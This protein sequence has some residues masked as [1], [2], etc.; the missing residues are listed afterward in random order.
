MSQNQIAR[1]RYLYDKFFNKRYNKKVIQT[2]LVN[3]NACS[4]AASEI[5][6]VAERVLKEFKSDIIGAEFGVAY[7]GGVEAIGKMWKG[8]G[9]IYG[10]D[11][12]E[13]QPKHIAEGTRAASA[14]D[15]WC[16]KYGKEKLAF[17][18]IQSVLD[19]QGL[20]NVKLV[21]GLITSDTK[22]D[23]IPYLD[24]VLLDLDFPI[25]MRQAY[26]LVKDKMTNGSYLCL[27]DVIPDGYTDTLF[28]LYLEIKNEN[29]YKVISENPQ[30]NLVILKR[31]NK[32]RMRIGG[33]SLVE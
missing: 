13:G 29:L 12:F 7:G 32:G 22:I 26:E 16:E 25:S 18:Y 33:I 2:V 5:L 1:L 6:Y 20:N 9:I 10:F 8:K 23:F 14:L 17:G 4:T 28:Q 19:S 11:T 3:L 31:E 24:Y 15:E 27:H 21:K 30:N